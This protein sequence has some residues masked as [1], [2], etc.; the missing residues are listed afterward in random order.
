MKWN[1][2]GRDPT[3]DAEP[4]MPL[5]WVLRDELGIT[6]PKHG[7]GIAHCGACKVHIER[8]AVRSFSLRVGGVQG[9]VVTIERLGHRDALHA[10]QKARIEHP[11]G[12][13]NCRRQPEGGLRR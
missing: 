12:G 1:V 8:W 7:C 2:N 9:S 10:V 11:A 5:L 4:E 3:V 13:E 6:G